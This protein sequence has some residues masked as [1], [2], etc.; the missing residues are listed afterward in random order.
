MKIDAHQ[1]FWKYDPAKQSWIDSTMGAIKHTFLPE[2]LY[3]DLD[4]NEIDG[5]V[6]VQAEESFRET[7]WLLDLTSKEE[8]IKAVVGWADLSSDDLEKDLDV[9]S[10]NSKLKGYR[11]VLQSKKPEYFLKPEFIR[12]LAK[13]GK[14]GYTYDLLVYSSQ[15]E[16]AFQLIKKSPEQAIVIDHL[17]K[18]QIK[19]GIWREWKKE[20][21][22]LAEREYIYCKLSGMVTEADWKNWKA[23]D[24]TP[25]LETALELFGPK[26]LMFGSDWP[27]CL[28][29]GS[30]SQ[31]AEVISEFIAPLSLSEK[32][33]IM[34]GT[35][36]E[37]YGIK[38]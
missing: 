17:A 2:N 36:M 13:I 29:A 33:Q 16:A 37:F 3:P 14:R 15:L 31:V 11:E 10:S 8:K 32:A 24:F 18:P 34:G 22:L 30:Y 1:H 27:V 20:M 35:A 19:L 9:F 23:S 7:A 26:R 6:V 21:S 25:Y 38:P 4:S 5:S 12:G 28:L